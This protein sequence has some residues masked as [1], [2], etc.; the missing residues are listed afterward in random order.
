[1]G[2]ACRGGVESQTVCGENA[3]VCVFRCNANSQQKN[4]KGETAYDLALKAGFESV[5]NKLA[6][7]IGQS[8]LGKL[9]KP[10]SSTTG[11]FD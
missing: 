4:D 11:V 10:K 7:N 5:G 2:V 3:F 9:V 6:S 8:A 1:M